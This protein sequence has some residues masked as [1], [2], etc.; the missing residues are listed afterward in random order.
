MGFSEY[1]ERQCQTCIHYRPRAN[2]RDN[3]QYAQAPHGRCES[4]KFVTGYRSMFIARGAPDIKDG[5]GPGVIERVDPDGV[6]VED[7]EGWGFYVGPEFGCV[8][9]ARRGD[10]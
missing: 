4:P 1:H 6:Q 8:H 9:H 7:D 10:Q 5:V 2:P 3:S